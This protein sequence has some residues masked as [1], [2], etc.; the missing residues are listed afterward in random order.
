MQWRNIGPFGG[1][2]SVTVHGVTNDPLTYYMGTV[3]RGMWKATDEGVAWNNMTDGA[4]NARGK[5]RGQLREPQNKLALQ[6][7][8]EHNPIQ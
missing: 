2:R 3:G 4:A 1:G 5:A 6:P 8:S 7:L